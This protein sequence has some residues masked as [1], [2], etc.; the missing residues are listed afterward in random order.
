MKFDARKFGLA[1]A[2][3]ALA[4]VVAVVLTSLML[5]SFGD[6]VGPVWKVFLA[7]PV[8][9]MPA[10]IL[11]S[12]AT[13]YLSGVAVAIGFRMNL[14]NIGVDGQYRVAMFAAAVFAGQGFL[15]GPVN[16]ALSIVLAMMVGALWAAIPALLKVYRGV[17][18]VIST[19]MLNSIATALVAWLLRK[20]AQS[21]EGSNATSTKRI[22]EDS[23]VPAM[24][25]LQTNISTV[26][27]LTIL[28]IVVGVAY[29]YVL[30]FTRFGFDLRTSGESAD[31]AKAAGV[32]PKKMVLA[33]MLIS[34]A[35]A[36]LVGMPALF[37]GDYA[38]GTNTQTGLGFSGIAV[39]LIG[40]NHPVGVAFGALLWAYLEGQANSL[41]IN[42]GVS[43][44]LVNIIQ[45][46]MVLAVIIAY[47]IVRR[48]SVRMERRQ[49]ASQLAEPAQAEPEGAKA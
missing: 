37:G 8:T 40:R 6:P 25:F 27:G 26:Y 49:V 22:A 29:W 28:A 19:I 4:I 33:A 31:A 7:A 46:I 18:E 11:N 35:V 24:P 3:P 1:L 42:A 10:T 32:N 41:Q 17:S 47:E 34:G 43:V 45:G 30:K 20:S 39:A 13:L 2:A 44:A 21:I 16:V 23:H 12:T 15:P 14:F 9:G 5:V 48:V 38:F 36:G